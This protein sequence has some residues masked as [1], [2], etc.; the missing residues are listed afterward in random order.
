MRLFFLL[1]PLV[2]NCQ[3][4]LSLDSVYK[5]VKQVFSRPVT[6]PISVQCDTGRKIKLNEL[7]GAI[8]ALDGSENTFMIDDFE[9]KVRAVFGHAIVDQ[10]IVPAENTSSEMIGKLKNIALGKVEK[11][12]GMFSRIRSFETLV[13]TVKRLWGALL[14]K[15]EYKLFLADRKS[16]SPWRSGASRFLSLASEYQKGKSPIVALG[17]VDL[18]D[19]MSRHV[20]K[21]SGFTRVTSGATT[22]TLL[23]EVLQMVSGGIYSADPYLVHG[24]L[25]ELQ[26]LI[27]ADIGFDRA[28]KR[29][30]KLYS[31]KAW[32]EI[33]ASGEEVLEG[34][35][36]FREEFLALRSA[37]ESKR[38]THVDNLLRIFN[39]KLSGFVRTAPR[40]VGEFI[41]PETYEERIGHIE[42]MLQYLEAVTNAKIYVAPR[43][44]AE[45]YRFKLAIPK[46]VLKINKG[47]RM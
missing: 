30:A 14:K 34:L 11:Y 27:L 20:S 6:D 15:N 39:S 4:D 44:F 29:H 17:V 24:K 46:V 12:C 25:V 40:E 32:T 37:E 31:G 5:K 19:T 7:K 43:V 8:E 42:L 28:S 13:L 45:C 10:W 47:E 33:A 23:A 21:E 2:C 18:L 22:D 9:A 16:V 3:F 41:M 38:A 26:G 1:L 35:A 36:L